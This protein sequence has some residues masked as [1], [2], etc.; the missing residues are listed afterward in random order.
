[1]LY[2]IPF[3]TRFFKI[4]DSFSTST[5]I[6]FFSFFNL[7]SYSILAF[8]SLIIIANK[9]SI[10]SIIFLKGTSSLFKI[11]ELSI[12]EIFKKSKTIFWSFFFKI[13]KKIENRG[14]PS[15]GWSAVVFLK[16]KINL[17]DYEI[18][19]LPTRKRDNPLRRPHLNLK[20]NCF[21]NLKS[22]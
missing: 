14:G 12:L 19:D 6:Y 20:C 4:I 15:T 21:F 3:S 10:F 8:F 17:F 13:S 22:D 11:F 5:T 18:K 16:K 1:M 2:I 9:L 7:I